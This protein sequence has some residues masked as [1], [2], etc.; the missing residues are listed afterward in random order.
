MRPAVDLEGVH[1]TVLDRESRTA[2]EMASERV[3]P[4]GDDEVP[5]ETATPFRAER[6][7]LGDLAT[8]PISIS[9]ED[10]A[11]VE[12][13]HLARQGPAANDR[14]PVPDAQ[15]CTAYRD[16]STTPA[17]DERVVRGRDDFAP[18][19]SPEPQQ[20]GAE[21]VP[22]DR[23][24]LLPDDSAFLRE[25]WNFQEGPRGQF[26]PFCRTF[27][28]DCSVHHEPIHEL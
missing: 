9:R 6:A 24:D 18:G 15:G 5:R 28:A 8:I 20:R 23:A 17:G 19:A 7:G 1:E 21:A 14:N 22:A 10:L 27:V 16:N 12:F 13:E 4:D 11:H 2:L 25:T 3:L 26:A